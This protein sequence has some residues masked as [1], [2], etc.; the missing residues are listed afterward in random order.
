M[1]RTHKKIFYYKRETNQTSWTFPDS[2]PSAAAVNNSEVEAVKNQAQAQAPTS[3]PATQSVKE[4]SVVQTPAPGPAATPNA[5]AGA[6]A[7]GT[8]VVST[9]PN[10]GRAVPSGPASWRNTQPQESDRERERK[11]SPP[12]SGDNKRSDRPDQPSVSD[13]D[14]DAKRTRMASPPTGPTGPASGNRYGPRSDNV[15]RRTLHS[16]LDPSQLVAIHV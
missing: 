1:S 6:G 4:N 13:S 3:T 5:A 15:P 8:A 11:R 10:T 16:A 12:P 14:R 7:T 9:S 2:P